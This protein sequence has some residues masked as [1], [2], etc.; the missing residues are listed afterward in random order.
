[1]I[2]GRLK[3]TPALALLLSATAFVP[4]ARAAERVTLRTGFQVD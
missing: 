3:L 1:M 4:C 2:H